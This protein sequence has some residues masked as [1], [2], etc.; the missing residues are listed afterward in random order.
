MRLLMWIVR[1]LG[2]SARRRQIREYILRE[3]IDIVGLQ[4]TVK[5]DFSS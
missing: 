3:R 5:E 4:E 1:G 2:K